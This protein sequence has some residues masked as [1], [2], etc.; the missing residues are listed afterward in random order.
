MAG[1]C[2]HQVNQK[3]EENAQS[4]LSECFFWKWFVYLIPFYLKILKRNSYYWQLEKVEMGL[5]SQ[6]ILEGF[7]IG[8]ALSTIYKKNSIPVS[9]CAEILQLCSLN[10]FLKIVE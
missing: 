5:V 4:I 8:H 1:I 6:F 3:E 2:P 10:L 9:Q 7:F